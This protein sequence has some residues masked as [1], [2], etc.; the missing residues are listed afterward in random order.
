ML[1]KC[2]TTTTTTFL[3][4]ILTVSTYTILPSI[5]GGLDL[6]FNH[7]I[8]LLTVKPPRLHI[9]KNGKQ[10]AHRLI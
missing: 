3:H 8:I 7:N 4:D 9:L 1:Q 5:A 2:L 10:P 6:S